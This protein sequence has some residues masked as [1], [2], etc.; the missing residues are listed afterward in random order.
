MNLFPKVRDISGKEISLVTIKDHVKNTLNLVVTTH[1]RVS[2]IRLNLQKILVPGKIHLHKQTG[3]VIYIELLKVT[4]KV[5]NLK[6]IV[7]RLEN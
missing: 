3:E 6:S 2:E 1:D 7:L 5:S 4:L